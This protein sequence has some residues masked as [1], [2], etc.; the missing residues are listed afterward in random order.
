VSGRL[1]RIHR[2]QNPSTDAMVRKRVRCTAH[3]KN[4]AARAGGASETY[5]LGLACTSNRTLPKMARSIRLVRITLQEAPSGGESPQPSTPFPKTE[6]LFAR[7]IAEDI[8][9]CT[10]GQVF[11]PLALKS[12]ESLFCPQEWC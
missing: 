7:L 12:S 3:P 8:D 1:P 2:F 4:P 11:E 5:V 9:Q 6:L 10:R